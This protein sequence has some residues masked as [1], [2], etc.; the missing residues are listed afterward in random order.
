MINL[1][2]IVQVDILWTDEFQRKD[3][4]AGEG[5]SDLQKDSGETEQ[6]EFSA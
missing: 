2:G 6:R 3:S 1:I 5:S 4:P